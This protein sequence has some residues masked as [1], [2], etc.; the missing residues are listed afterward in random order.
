MTYQHILYDV[1]EKIATIRKKNRRRREH[2]RHHRAQN[3]HDVN[4]RQD[5]HEN[6]VFPE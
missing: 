6:K 4:Q 5:Q 3:Q 2:Q 1:S